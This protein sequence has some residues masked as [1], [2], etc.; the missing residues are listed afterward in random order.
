MGSKIF[1]FCI[2]VKNLTGVTAEA[3]KISKKISVRFQAWNVCEVCVLFAINDRS[4]IK[5][6]QK[7]NLVQIRRIFRE[8]WSSKNYFSKTI[9][10]NMKF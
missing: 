3:I 2:M 4:S 7:K 6:S 1:G 8:F 9:I 10:Q 5:P